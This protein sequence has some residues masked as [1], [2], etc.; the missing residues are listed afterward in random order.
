AKLVESPVFRRGVFF[1]ECATVQPARLVRALR[2]AVLDAG[3]VLHEGTRAEHIA[4]GEVTTTGGSV[5]ADA[6]VVAMNAAASG[7]R[8]VRRHVTN[9][10]SYVVLTEPVPE[11]LR[12]IGWTGGEAV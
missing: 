2:R 8:P 3:V 5:R 1:P 9:F 6:I 11:L 10:G 4:D 12:E 7:W